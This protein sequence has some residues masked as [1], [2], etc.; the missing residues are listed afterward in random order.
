MIAVFYDIVFFAS[1]TSSFLVVG[2]SMLGG[3]RG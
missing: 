2:A 3:S 1:A